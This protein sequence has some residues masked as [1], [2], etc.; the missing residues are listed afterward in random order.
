[1]AQGISRIDGDGVGNAIT[2]VQDDTGGTS[3]GVQGKYSLVSHIHSRYLE[4]L[5]HN[6]MEEKQHTE[7]DKARSV[8]N[9][10]MSIRKFFFLK[11]L[12]TVG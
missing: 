7:K 8:S 9:L 10:Y 11:Q 5:K 12:A 2:K 3:R 1:M 4:R 6:L